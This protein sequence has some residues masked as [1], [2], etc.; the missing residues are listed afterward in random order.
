MDGFTFVEHTRA[1]PVLRDIPSI[2]V[3]SR[4]SDEDRRRGVEAG[5]R[6]HVAKNDFDQND[7]LRHIGKLVS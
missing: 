3:S 7:L 1:D 6:L 5:A 2:L 4:A